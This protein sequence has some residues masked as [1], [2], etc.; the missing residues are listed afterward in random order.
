MTRTF[1]SIAVSVALILAASTATPGLTQRSLIISL[2]QSGVVAYEKGNYREA[3]RIFRQCQEMVAKI[4]HNEAEE[5]GL[6]YS[7]AETLRSVGQLNEAEETFKRS[8]T[9][10]DTL[11]AKRRNYSFLWNG[12]ALLY[13]TQGRFSEAEQLWKQSEVAAKG[14]F[15]QVL[16]PVNNLARHYFLWGK[17]AD[18]KI[19]VEK[20]AALAKK[21]PPKSLAITYWLFNRAQLSEQLGQYKQADAQYKEALDSCQKNFGATHPYSGLI[22]TNMSD[23]YR[24]ESRYSDAEESLRAALKIFESQYPEDHPDVCETMVR[25]GRVL[26][27]EGKYD[28]ART[29]VAKALKLEEGLFGTG[30]NLF[31]ARAKNCMGNIY[32]QDGRYQDAQTL[33]EAALSAEKHILG[34]DKV[35]TAITMRDLALVQMDLANF[36]EAISLLQSS[37]RIIE[38]QTGPEHPE[39]AAALNALAHAYLRDQKYADA[40]PLLK[41]ALEL[42]EATMGQDNAVTASGARDLGEL[43]MKQKQYA[44]A[45]TYL[46]KALNID[47]KIF[48]KSAPQVAADLFSLAACY[49]EQGQSEKAQPLLA[50][51]AEIKNVLPGGSSKI[52][53]PQIA[54]SSASDRPVTDKWALVVGVSTFKD[55]SINLKFAAKDATDFKNFLINNQKFKPDHVKLL[56]NESA[57]RENIIGML[58][59][60]WLATHVKP[61]DM[62][63]VYV[64]SHG[65]AAADQAGGTNFLIAHDT[66]KNSLAATGIPMQWLTSIVAEQVRSNRIILILDVCHSGSVSEGQKGLTR[67]AGI[68]ANA[69]KIGKGQM[70]ICSSLADQISWE[71]KNYENSVFTR[72]LMEALQSDKGQTSML[73]AYKRLKVLVESEVLRDRG[74]L[75]TPLMISKNWLGK[76][77]V[78]SVEAGAEAGK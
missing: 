67:T 72:C 21:A 27:D 59:E 65:S 48:G 44:D 60:K 71:S 51:A 74:N 31:I 17:V 41:K 13:Q 39:R 26:S 40:E 35:E 47:E 45:E 70:V 28:K 38:Q 2:Y 46:Q 8:M 9:L 4:K 73:E 19:Y 43:Y 15:Q 61:D 77:P 62:V 58:G 69:L 30:D 5:S 66:N 53:M 52:E 25:I 55:S 24:K 6:L 29:I 33:L 42:S 22:L 68:D 76:D 75:Q 16:Y 64:S 34:Q 10:A 7:L 57:S 36:E 14:N 54:N 37:L 23:L 3:L 1:L 50:R 12:M 49:A 20:A 18:E 78:L 11:P 63:V 56:T 32:R